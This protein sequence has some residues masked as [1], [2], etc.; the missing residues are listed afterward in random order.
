MQLYL[1]EVEVGKLSIKVERTAKISYSL[2]RL[3]TIREVEVG[4]LKV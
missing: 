4:K 3:A 1:R 2:N